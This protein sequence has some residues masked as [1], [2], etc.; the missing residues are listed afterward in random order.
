MH[1]CSSLRN[2]WLTDTLISTI[3]I[4]PNWLI[5]YHWLSCYHCFQVTKHYTSGSGYF[6]SILETVGIVTT[7][8]LNHFELVN[9]VFKRLSALSAQRGLLRVL[10]RSICF[11]STLHSN[12]SWITERVSYYRE[13]EK[14]S[15][16][17]IPVA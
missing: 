12:Y 10:Q 4:V 1:G 16:E 11:H 13:I 7:V 14:R 17:N 5:V 2:I 3:I 6:D 8:L 9:F 15:Y